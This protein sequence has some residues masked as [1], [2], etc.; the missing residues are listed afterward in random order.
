MTPAQRAAAQISTYL[1]TGMHHSTADAQRVM[2]DIISIAM[3]QDRRESPLIT[4]AISRLAT[5]QCPHCYARI[6][7]TLDC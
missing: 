6:G 7:T 5:L 4:G 2:D 3:L 1:Q